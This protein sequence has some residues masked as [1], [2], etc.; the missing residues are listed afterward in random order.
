MKILGIG[1]ALVDILAKLPNDNLLGEL[2][3]PKGSMNLIDSEQRKVIFE[4]INGLDLKMT[5]GGSVSNTT[6]A[7]GQLGIPVGYI[8]KIGD[9]IYGD[10]YLQEMTAS[11][12]DLHLIQEETFSGTAMA[13]IS[14]DGE[15]TFCTYLGAAADMQKTDLQETIFKTY[16]HFYV[17]G[18]LVQNHE[19]METAMQMAKSQGLKI[20]IDLSSYNVVAADRNFILNLIDNYVDIVFAN[21]EEAIALTQK[22]TIE[23]VHEIAAKVQMAIIKEGAKGSYVKS[24]DM[25]AHIPVLKEIKPV[26]TTAAGD[27]YAAGFFYGMAN[28]VNPEK[29]AMLGTLL[30]YYVIQVVGTKLSAE[31]WN[32]I[33]KKAC[34]IIKN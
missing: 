3:V 23:A 13:M 12:V 15:R 10:F 22:Q 33:R 25:F 32:E 5:T 8:G 2:N 6:V 17:E 31:M 11:G 27:Y 24:K 26:D 1:N 21:E 16:S 14:P 30:S 4:K 29:C 19:L 20:I 7:L 28:G 18:Y 9:D 34:G